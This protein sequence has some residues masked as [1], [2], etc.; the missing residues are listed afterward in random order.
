MRSI[1][2]VSPILKV[3][4]RDEMLQTCNGVVSMNEI[5][6]LVEVWSLHFNKVFKFVREDLEDTM[7]ESLAKCSR[8]AKMF[9][10]K[11]ASLSTWVRLIVSHTFY[12]VFR[13]SD[14]NTISLDD[15]FGLV[16]CWGDSN[17]TADHNARYAWVE[18]ELNKLPQEKRA[19]M[20]K[21]LDETS[22][23]DIAK[24]FG[25]TTGKVSM[26]VHHV[27]EKLRQD[28]K[29]QAAS[30]LDIDAPAA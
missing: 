23:A 16:A 17:Y 2:L 25:Y 12:D 13:R 14:E 18:R 21:Y 22:V 4:A 29:L 6:H 9:D 30:G 24:E 28:L 26:M 27:T 3:G 8:N 11:R 10:C 5:T 20:K 7:I 19:V 1:S 15:V